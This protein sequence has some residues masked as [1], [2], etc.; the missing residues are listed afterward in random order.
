M[1]KKELRSEAAFQTTM[2]LARQMLGQGMLDKE[3]Y[4]RFEQEM[5]DRYKPFF[6]HLFS[7]ITLTL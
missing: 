1:T 5:L 6:G 4:C 2:S 7:E 3:E